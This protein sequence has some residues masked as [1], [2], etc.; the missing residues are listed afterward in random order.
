MRTI[1]PAWSAPS[2]EPVS[3]IKVLLGK[4]SMDGHDRGVRVLARL[5]RDAGME[6]VYLGK[7]LPHEAVIEAAIQENAQ[8]VGLS[9]LSGEHASHTRRFARALR[10]RGL[11]EVLFLVGGVIPR[12]DIAELLEAGADGVFV[13]GTPVEE[14]VGFIRE[15][16]GA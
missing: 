1:R 16:V 7:F 2:S 15:R 9:F 12:Q 14:V 8:V 4:V 10:S 3:A 5:L 11:T 6:V 13:A